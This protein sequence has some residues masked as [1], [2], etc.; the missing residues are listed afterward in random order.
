MIV[1]KIGNIGCYEKL[2]KNNGKIAE[3]FKNNSLDSIAQA[4]ES[5][6][7]YSIQSPRATKIS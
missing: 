7:C 4:C 5:G 6:G 3:F 1:D 2:V